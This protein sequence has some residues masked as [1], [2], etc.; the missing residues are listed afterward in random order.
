[1]LQPTGLTVQ[2]SSNASFTA[3]ATGD[4]P[5]SYQWRKGANPISGA[6]NTSLSVPNA[7]PTDIANYTFVVSN[8]FGVVTSSVATLTVVDTIAPVIVC[9]PNIAVPATS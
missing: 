7:H 2:C 8:A 4:V 1:T 3:S 6:T 9:S 5:I